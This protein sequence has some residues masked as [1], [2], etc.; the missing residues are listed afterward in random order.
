[1]HVFVYLSSHTFQERLSVLNLGT[2]H[3]DRDWHRIENEK[4]RYYCFTATLVLRYVYVT[5][6]VLLLYY[7][8]NHTL[9][10]LY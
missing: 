3:T 6:S 9:L 1:M 10:L 7:C 8:L 5:T 2:G 4:S